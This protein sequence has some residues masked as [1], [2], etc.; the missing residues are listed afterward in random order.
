MGVTGWVIIAILIVGIAAALFGWDRYRG[1][2]KSASGSAAQPTG[3]GF[4]LPGHGPQDARLV[5]PA[6]GETRL[7]ARVI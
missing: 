7:P 1:S 6:F 2:R 4:Y 3:R 5:R